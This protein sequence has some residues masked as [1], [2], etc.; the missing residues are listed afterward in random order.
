[1]YIQIAKETVDKF[2]CTSSCKFFKNPGWTGVVQ[3]WHTAQFGA[4][5]NYHNTVG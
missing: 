2:M 1:M 5:Q 3:I 4:P